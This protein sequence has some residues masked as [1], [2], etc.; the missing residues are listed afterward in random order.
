MAPGED[1]YIGKVEQ[2]Y[3]PAAFRNPP[4]ATQNGQSDYS[5]LGGQ[6]TQVTGPPYRKL[7]L[8][9]FKDFLFTERFRLQF[10]AES[11]NLTNTPAFAN[12][13]VTNFV[14]ARNFGR[15][16]ATRNNPND[17]RQIQMALKLYF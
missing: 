5:P 7:D 9:L 12:P 2:W 13:S 16:T 1:L 4:V 3:N 10:R 17:A 11:F 15:V 6:R 14:D 8:S